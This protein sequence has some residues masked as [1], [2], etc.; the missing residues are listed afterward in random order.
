MENFRNHTLQEKMRT[1]TLQRTTISPLPS[2]TNEHSNSMMI[3]QIIAIDPK[4]W[5]P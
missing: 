2:S 1:M 4:S 3:E 5:T